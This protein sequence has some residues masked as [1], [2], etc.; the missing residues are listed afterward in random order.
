MPMHV[1][2]YARYNVHLAPFY[3]EDL[4]LD[5]DIMLGVILSQD[6]QLSADKVSIQSLSPGITRQHMLHILLY[7][8]IHPCDWCG[9]PLRDSP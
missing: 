2:T 7:I 8:N 3:A 5:V 4:T 6:E 9:V 1:P